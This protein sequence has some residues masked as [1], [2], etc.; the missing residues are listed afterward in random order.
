MTAGQR[1]PAGKTEHVG[2]N[3]SG[4]DDVE[5]GQRQCAGLVEHD[6]VDIG[7]ALDGIA[8]IDQHAGAE[9]GTGHHRLHRG[10]W[11]ARARRDR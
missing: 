11:Q 8:G 7:D 1:Q 9:H 10:K 5:V 3:G 4:H 6:G 2:R